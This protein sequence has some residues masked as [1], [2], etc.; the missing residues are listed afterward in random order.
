MKEAQHERKTTIAKNTNHS[1]GTLRS[2]SVNGLQIVD[3]NFELIHHFLML[4]SEI[5]ELDFHIGQRVCDALR[6]EKR[7]NCSHHS[8][9]A[10]KKLKSFAISK[11]SEYR[12]LHNIVTVTHARTRSHTNT[13]LRMSSDTLLMQHELCRADVV[14]VDF[15]SL[16]SRLV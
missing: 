1:L 2:A 9:T 11:S 10:S 8:S 7:E 12:T 16:E 13:H 6:K 5:I 3:I 4:L 15:R 14:N